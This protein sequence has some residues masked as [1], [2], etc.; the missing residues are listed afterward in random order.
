VLD[1]NLFRIVFSIC[2]RFDLNIRY[3][4]HIHEYWVVST[5]SYPLQHYLVSLADV[6]ELIDDEIKVEEAGAAAI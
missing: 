4:K 3:S 2:I 1:S 6:A 5:I